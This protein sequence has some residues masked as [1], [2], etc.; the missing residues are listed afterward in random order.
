MSAKDTIIGTTKR[1]VAE[2][3]GDG[4]LADKGSRQAHGNASYDDPISGMTGELQP[5]PSS[6]S[7]TTTSR[8]STATEHDR[9]ALLLGH[10]ALSVWPDLS[11]DAQER[12]FYAAVDDSIIANSLAVFL[13]KRHPKTVHPPEPSQLA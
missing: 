9:F 8:S 4:V 11:R 7:E 10:A 2:I 13:H 6:L 5:P 1:L 12:L 3:V